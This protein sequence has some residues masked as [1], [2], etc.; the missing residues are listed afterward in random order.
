MISIT[1]SPFPGPL[2][3]TVT[4]K[5]PSH[6]A[7]HRRI[8]PP[9]QLSIS[10]NESS[11]C[12]REYL[13]K[14][15]FAVSLTFSTIS[16]EML[17]LSGCGHRGNVPVCFYFAQHHQPLHIY[18][19]R[20]NS[21]AM[22]KRQRWGSCR[23][24]IFDASVKGQFVS[25]REQSSTWG[26]IFWHTLKGFTHILKYYSTIHILIHSL[27]QRG[28]RFHSVCHCGPPEYYRALQKHFLR[29][30]IPLNTCYVFEA[31]GE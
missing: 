3:E 19:C 15:L 17:L 28:I 31:V 10:Y 14:A 1:K 24:T 6:L 21:S 8:S 18:H 29:K 20:A 23:D 12:T 27:W 13:T 5:S 7:M 4:L 30:S 11:I 25:S 22:I 9:G 2:L 16:R 26:E